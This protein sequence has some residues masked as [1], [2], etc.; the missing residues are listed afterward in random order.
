[1][2]LFTN[3]HTLQTEARVGNGYHGGKRPLLGG[4]SIDFRMVDIKIERSPSLK[5]WEPTYRLSYVHGMILT[6][7]TQV[8]DFDTSLDNHIIRGAGS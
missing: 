1:M 5:D 2:K 8:H 7:S 6:E 3:M 4:K